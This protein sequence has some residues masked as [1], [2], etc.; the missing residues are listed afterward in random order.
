[1]CSL[2]VACGASQ[3]WGR[4]ALNMHR[5]PAPLPFAKKRKVPLVV[6]GCFFLQSELKVLNWQALTEHLLHGTMPDS[7]NQRNTR[8][9]PFFQDNFSEGVP[10]C[11]G[12]GLGVECEKNSGWNEQHQG[13]VTAAF[14]DLRPA[15]F[16]FLGF[17]FLPIKWKN[18]I[19]CAYGYF[20]LW[21]SVFVIY[22]CIMNHPQT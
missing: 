21:P 17:I 2:V 12:D 7:G 14:Y 6:V 3:T 10:W 20:Q 15:S 13:L 9:H 11:T 5:P 16:L 22:C 8:H 19:R 18:W 1:M 4:L